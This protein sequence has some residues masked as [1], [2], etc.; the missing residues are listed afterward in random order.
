MAVRTPDPRGAPPLRS[1]KSHAQ[2]AH[3]SGIKAASQHNGVIGGQGCGGEPFDI[4]HRTAQAFPQPL[5]IALGV[6]MAGGI[7]HHWFHRSVT[8]VPET[9]TISMPLSLPSTS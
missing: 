6:A 1:A 9:L 4:P 8:A 7:E 2:A 3:A 5:S